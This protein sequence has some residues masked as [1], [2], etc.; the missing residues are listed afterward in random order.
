MSSGF[1]VSGLFGDTAG[2]DDRDTP[3]EF[4]PPDDDSSEPADEDLS[5]E[6]GM[7]PI[8]HKNK[9]SLSGN[10]NRNHD[11][12]TPRFYAERLQFL[13]DKYLVIV[14]LMITLSGGTVVLLVNRLSG[15]TQAGLGNRNYLA[16]SAG[17]GA[18]AF[19]FAMLWRFSSQVV[20]ERQVYGPQARARG[21]FVKVVYDSLNGEEMPRHE[22][23][24]LP[25]A[26]RKQYPTRFEMA[27][28]VLVYPLLGFLL[29]SWLCA[30]L[31][32]WTATQPP[33]PPPAQS[34]EMV[35]PAATRPARS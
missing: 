34:P 13:W 12:F 24:H 2:A 26:V 29:A 28:S 30:A 15:V 33:T 16:L 4:P 35:S 11:E 21:Y 19:V 20:M 27:Y 32:M 31:W 1:L 9:G 5:D 25:T 7:N 23:W 3:E 6:V 14:H 17:L 22:I 18:L 10:V 8:R